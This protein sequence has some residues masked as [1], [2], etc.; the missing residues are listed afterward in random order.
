MAYRKWPAILTGCFYFPILFGSLHNVHASNSNFEFQIKHR[1]ADCKVLFYQHHYC[2]VLSFF[3]SWIL[4]WLYDA[5]IELVEKFQ[6]MNLENGLNFRSGNKSNF[7]VNRTSWKCIAEW[8][9]SKSKTEFQN[10]YQLRTFNKLIITIAS[11][12]FVN[13]FAPKIRKWFSFTI[14]TVVVNLNT[15]INRQLIASLHVHVDWNLVEC[16]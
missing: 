8:G 10:A 4:V 12:V 14:A 5:H 13:L 7:N 16:K 11:K 1:D 3:S 9:K 15:P 6:R 2:H